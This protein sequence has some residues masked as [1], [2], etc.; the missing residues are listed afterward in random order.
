MRSLSL[1]GIL[2]LALSFAAA[3]S[4][5]SYTTGATNVPP[6]T[7]PAANNVFAASLSGT[8]EVPP[9]TTTATGTATFTVNAS[10]VDFKIEVQGI[11]D[12]VAGHIHSG[13]AGVNGPVRVTLV[14]SAVPGVTNGVLAQGSFTS[15][16][17]SGV[18]YDELLN[19]IRNGTAYVNVHTVA[20]P[21]GEIRGQIGAK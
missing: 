1:V 15:S 3:C 21:G 2:C 20:N 16:G 11:T 4:D 5:N 18:T 12:V 9:T 7:V 8:S 13:A 10:S 17:V 19:E 14:E 6:T